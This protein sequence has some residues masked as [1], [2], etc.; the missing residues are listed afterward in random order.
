[1]DRFLIG[2]IL[3]SDNTKL[4]NTSKEMFVKIFN[5]IELR[6]DLFYFYQPDTLVT[7]K[8]SKGLAAFL[9]A[10]PNKIKFSGA[11][12]DTFDVIDNESSDDFVKMVFIITDNYKK[13]E[14]F[15][16]QLILRQYDYSYVFFGV[17]DK[18]DSLKKLG[19]S[20]H[21]DNNQLLK[22]EFY[23]FIDKMVEERKNGRYV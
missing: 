17:G 6:Y 23:K 11:L 18:C 19:L 7:N 22:E 16:S 21:V 5:K 3:H 4:W 12:R 10:K 9:N 1:M 14:E 2:L 8:N 13:D 15:S 20:I